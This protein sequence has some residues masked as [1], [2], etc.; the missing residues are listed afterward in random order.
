M[1]DV[2]EIAQTSVST[3]DS[4]G[5]GKYIVIGIVCVIAIVAFVVLG[6]MSKK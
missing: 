2:L 4:G 6:K 3:G 5:A 1:Y